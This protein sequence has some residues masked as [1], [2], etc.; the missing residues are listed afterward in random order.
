MPP[1]DSYNIK[2]CFDGHSP[3]IKGNT[4]TTSFKQQSSRNAYDKMYVPGYTMKSPVVE[5]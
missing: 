5:K 3:T 2:T 1:P 4:L